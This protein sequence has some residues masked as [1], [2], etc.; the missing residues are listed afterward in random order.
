MSTLKLFIKMKKYLLEI[1]D[2][3][4]TKLCLCMHTTSLLSLKM[5]KIYFRRIY[6]S[7]ILT[8]QIRK[9]S[10]GWSQWVHVLDEPEKD[11][12]DILGLQ[13]IN[14]APTLSRLCNYRRIRHREV[15][16]SQR[17]LPPAQTT[18]QWHYNLNEL[19]L[20]A[21]EFRQR[22]NELEEPTILFCQES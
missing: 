5:L 6:W 10:S 14:Q 4:L 3:V 2:R 20:R 7:E 8:D 21:A 12:T 11:K 13:Q 1:L 16:R 18:G 9:R 15:L 22:A 19:Q 17:A